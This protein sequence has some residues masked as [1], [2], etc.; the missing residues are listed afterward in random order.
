M[1]HP[2]PYQP[3]LLR[4]VH[5]LAGGLAIASILTGFWVY[6]TY[7][8]R[9][10]RLPLPTVNEVEGLHGT[11]GLL[12]LLTF[13]AL[14]IYSLRVGYRRLIQPN[15]LNVLVSQVNHPRWWV[16]LQ[17][18][19]NTSLLLAAILSLI[20]GRMMQEEWMAQQELH[21]MAYSLHLLGWVVM[22]VAVLCHLLINAKVG[23]IPLLLSMVN[24]QYLPKESPRHWPGHIQRWAK[25]IFLSIRKA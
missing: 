25:K 9:F 24:W 14:A 15:T 10:G 6:N 17:R 12:F 8:G 22:V 21:H 13:P 7:D 4:V 16:T 11:F 20:T 5:A 19:V 3:F 23:G 18:V 1:K 2:I